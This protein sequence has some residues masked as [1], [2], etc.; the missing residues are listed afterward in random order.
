M[1]NKTHNNKTQDEPSNKDEF[2]LN[3]MLYDEENFFSEKNPN[4]RNYDFYIGKQN[5]VSYMNGSNSNIIKNYK[6]PNHMYNSS[7]Q[8]PRFFHK[9]Y[10]VENNFNFPNDFNNI[11]KMIKK[12]KQLKR[13]SKQ[14]ICSNCETTTTPS[15]RRGGNEKLLL[16]NACGLYLK[17]HGRNRPYSIN[18]EGKTK[19]IKVLNNKAICIVCNTMGNLCEMKTTPNGATCYTCYN[20]FAHQIMNTK[21]HNYNDKKYYDQYYNN[22]KYYNYYN[23]WRG[24]PNENRISD[25]YL[26]SISHMYMDPYHNPHMYNNISEYP[27]ELYNEYYKKIYE[28]P[29]NSNEK[30]ATSATN[31]QYSQKKYEEENYKR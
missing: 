23:N 29:T 8:I 5:N 20:Y 26:Y 4:N 30:T 28:S 14:R 22:Y 16:C 25:P 31:L 11:N 9:P 21:C 1:N 6:T 7:S 13:K 15:W 12:Q 17:L 24:D 10:K 3:S 19:A 18:Q 27:Q 2:L